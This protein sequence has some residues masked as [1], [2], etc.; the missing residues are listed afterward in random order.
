MTTKHIITLLTTAA[1]AAA[2][3]F[4]TS[5]GAYAPA[6]TAAIAFA[7]GFYHLYLNPPANR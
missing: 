7:G 5:L 4:I 3:A 1:L 2:P 6:V